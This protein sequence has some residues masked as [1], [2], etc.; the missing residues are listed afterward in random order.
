M[1]QRSCPRDWHNM[2][3]R[4]ERELRG[5]R[6]GKGGRSLLATAAP[7]FFVPL[8]FG[9]TV[10]EGQAVEVYVRGGLSGSTALV[11]DAVA[12]AQVGE[13][14]GSEV[15]DE[16]RAV[17]RP[18]P[19]LGGGVR[20]E[21]WPRVALV[22]DA[23]WARNELEAEDGAGTRPVQ[24]LDVIQV[25]VGAQWAV[26][27]AVELGAGAGLQWYRTEETGLF[28][29]G[30]DTSPLV[31]VTAGWTPSIWDGRLAVI[32]A[33]QTHR[34]GTPVLRTAGGQDGMVTRF[35]LTGRLRLLE[36][37]R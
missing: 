13:L 36:V 29:Q 12:T 3:I 31:V 2:V 27:P 25:Q 20:V 22:A 18:G 9:A 32:A 33:A 35:S 30:S 11:R 16:V 21:F 5:E 7:F 23:E 34:F 28:A 17:P 10:L 8:L 4:G 26:R 19:V 14:L 15:D 37:N 1:W 6:R 24:D